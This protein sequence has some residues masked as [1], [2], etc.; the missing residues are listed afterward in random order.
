MSSLTS[1]FSAKVLRYSALAVTTVPDDPS[2]VMQQ[3]WANKMLSERYVAKELKKAKRAKTKPH[4]VVG[5][6]FPWDYDADANKG[7]AE[8]FPN[9]EVCITIPPLLFIIF[10]F[11]TYYISTLDPSFET[12]I[13]S[14]KKTT[15][16]P[17]SH[18]LLYSS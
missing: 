17:Q 3:D 1:L 6:N 12:R 8:D 4:I 18:Y 5:F 15:P 16:Q 9:T 14:D 10:W 11:I 13:Q 2:S 7:P